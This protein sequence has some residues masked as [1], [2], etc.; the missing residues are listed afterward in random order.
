MTHKELVAGLNWQI[1]DNSD[2]LKL[3]K[4]ESFLLDVMIKVLL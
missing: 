1:E 2:E 3:E 4:C